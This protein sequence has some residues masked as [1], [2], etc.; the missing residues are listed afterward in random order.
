M[1]VFE[2]AFGYVTTVELGYSVMKGIDCP[3]S[4]YMSVVLTKEYNGVVNSEEL[5]GT[6]SVAIDKELH[7]PMAL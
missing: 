3:V 1:I 4:L 6:T 2:I 7:K 5:I